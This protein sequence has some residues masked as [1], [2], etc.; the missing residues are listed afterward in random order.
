MIEQFPEIKLGERNVTKHFKLLE[1]IK[2]TIESRQ[3]YLVSELEQDIAVGGQSNQDKASLYRR[4]CELIEIKEILKHD[5]LRVVLLY[6]LK[7]EGDKLCIQLNDSLRSKGISTDPIAQM[8]HIFGKSE[9]GEGPS[10][11][12]GG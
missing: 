8:L 7:Y 3:L 4:V 6:N 11:Q 5:K 9:R 12:L 1:S 10:A 2:S